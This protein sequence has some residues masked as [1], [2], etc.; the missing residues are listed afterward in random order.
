MG[1]GASAPWPETLRVPPLKRLRHREHVLRQ[2]PLHLALEIF[3]DTPVE[4]IR[5]SRRDRRLRMGI[6]AWRHRCADRPGD[7]HGR[8][9]GGDAADFCTA[10]QA[11]LG[12]P[13]L[14]N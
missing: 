2:P 1:A 5:R 6:P 13:H 3:R 12:E 10:L 14:R 4:R 9:G 7:L 11:R 8:R